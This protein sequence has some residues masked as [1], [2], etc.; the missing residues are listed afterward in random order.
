MEQKFV[1]KLTEYVSTTEECEKLKKMK[2]QLVK[3]IEEDHRTYSEDGAKRTV[4]VKG[5]DYVVG[6]VKGGMNSVNKKYVTD[7][8]KERLCQQKIAPT[9]TNITSIVGDMFSVE[10]LGYRNQK[11]KIISPKK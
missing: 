10:S 4:N 9:P 1:A 3:E 6:Y 7:F 5:Q 2:S 11:F 8:L